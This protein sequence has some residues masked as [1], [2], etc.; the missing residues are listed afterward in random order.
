MILF[1]LV[2][3]KPLPAKITLDSLIAL[4]GVDWVLL[5]EAGQ[6][7]ATRALFEF[8]ACLDNRIVARDAF[9]AAACAFRFVIPLL[10]GDAI[11]DRIAGLTAASIPPECG[12]A[13]S[14]SVLETVQEELVW[15]KPAFSAELQFATNYVQRPIFRRGALGTVFIADEAA[16]YSGFPQWMETLGEIHHI[17]DA[18]FKIAS[19]FTDNRRNLLS[20]RASAA[21][22]ASALGYSRFTVRI[23]RESST[24][25]GRDFYAFDLEFEDQGPAV[26]IVIPTKDHAGVLQV[27]I[28][29]IR[30]KTTYKNYR[31]L[32]VNNNSELDETR[33]YFAQLNHDPRVEV[34]DVEN[35]AGAGFNYSYVNNQAVQVADSELICF[36]N[37]D[38]EVINPRW[39]TQLAGVASNTQVGSAGALLLYPNMTV[40]HSG[41]HFGLLYNKL[42]TT[43]FKNL[44]ERQG[45]YFGALFAMRNYMALSAACLVVKRA[46]FLAQGGF[47]EDN[48][49]VAY[50]DCDYGIRTF[51]A[52]KR[53]V[54]CPAAV[55]THFEGYSRGTG[56]GNDHPHEEA[57]FMRMHDRKV[58][59]F[60]NRW[61]AT[62]SSNFEVQR[63]PRYPIATRTARR[64]I[65][66]YSHNLNYEGA[67]LVLFDLVNAL[68]GR[69]DDALTVVAPFDGLLA[70][71]YR[72]IGVEVCI[73]P[74]LGIGG[75][76]TEASLSGLLGHC[77]ARIA[78]TNADL[79]I[80]NTVLGFQF[81][82]AARQLELPAVWIIHESEQPFIHLREHGG[83]AEY[84]AKVA[85]HEATQVTFVCES[86]R[87]YYR[88]MLGLTTNTSV[89]YNAVD[90]DFLQRAK[91]RLS[92][93]QARKA[94]KIGAGLKVGICVGVVCARKRQHDI[95]AIARQLNDEVA[96][97]ILLIVVGDRP[98]EYS[99]ELRQ[100][101][102]KLGKR[103]AG[104]RIVHETPD[105]YP[106]FIAA[107][108][109][110]FCSE[111][112]SYPR[113]LQE[114]LFF[115]LPVITTKVFGN[116]EIVSG[117]RNGLFFDVGDTATAAGHIERFC[118]DQAFAAELTSRCAAGVGRFSSIDKFAGAYLDI[119]NATLE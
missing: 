37:N 26:T 103:V 3:H 87:E 31:I 71:R 35:K 19:L 100:Q 58:D 83:V 74:A 93:R 66:V 111:M 29:S 104:I 39:L 77:R 91:S 33:R 95:V 32:V 46:D 42:P 84:F 22:Y 81:I 69:T 53:N 114:A 102:N 90:T 117:G 13:Y 65:L 54:F 2:A 40:Q 50:N 10:E 99:T 106:Y 97:N 60:H 80:A 112:E 18:Y 38:T 15:A 43:A 64:A 41:I 119:I 72:N 6:Q 107:D 94:L 27:C 67:P 105:P 47:D 116:K 76:H 108:F 96:E 45:A 5:Y 101:V 17:Q 79:V 28:D 24:H 11:T 55:L 78:A 118:T 36:L 52:G 20:T 57:A 48:F 75:A 61:C 21:R 44:P 98:G 9:D 70:D 110:L 62:D 25:L 12:W 92:K 73:E 23:R 115:D 63:L 88:H 82:L 51:L 4:Q 8:V 34:I 86:T 85:A 16:V 89:V 59:P 30:E 113:V 7:P 49:G 109:F 56:I 68:R 14:D 1:T